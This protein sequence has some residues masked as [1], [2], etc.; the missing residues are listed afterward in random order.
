M[1]NR[2]LTRALL[3]A[4]EGSLYAFSWGINSFNF[5]GSLT[6]TATAT[7][8]NYTEQRADSGDSSMHYRVRAGNR[9]G[10]SPYSP[11]LRW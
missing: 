9:P 3:M 6:F 5:G 2:R 10:W 11:P 1:A 4:V 8:F 7:A